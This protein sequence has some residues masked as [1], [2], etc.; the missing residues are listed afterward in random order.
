MRERETKMHV[1][2]WITIGM[3]KLFAEMRNTIREAG[4]AAARRN[5]DAL[6]DHTKS[7]ISGNNPLK[8]PTVK[9][10]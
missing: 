7:E 8:S 5:N 4:L 2:A 9:D 10:A 1:L 3:G 6:F